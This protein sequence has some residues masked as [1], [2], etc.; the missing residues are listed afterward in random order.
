MFTVMVKVLAR[1]AEWHLHLFSMSFYS[2][3]EK[4]PS[5]ARQ[6]QTRWYCEQILNDLNIKIGHAYSILLS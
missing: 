1:R 3:Q 4:L 5:L 2:A 6:R